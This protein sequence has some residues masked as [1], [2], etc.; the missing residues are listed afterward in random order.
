MATQP[1][2]PRSFIAVGFETPNALAMSAEETV[3]FARI[4]F[5]KACS[6]GGFIYAFVYAFAAVFVFLAE[7]FLT[8][9]TGKLIDSIY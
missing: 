6:L 2:L 1:I 8:L 4:V 5:F 7:F 9:W 3:P